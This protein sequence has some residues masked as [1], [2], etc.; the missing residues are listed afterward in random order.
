M[1]RSKK[2]ETA[3]R[4]SEER[5][6]DAKYGEYDGHG[7]AAREG[8]PELNTQRPSSGGEK[9]AGPRPSKRR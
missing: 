3:W 9:N 7:R 6:Y 2:T 1:R 4:S 5:A 8:R